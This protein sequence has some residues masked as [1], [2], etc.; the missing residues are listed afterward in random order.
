[1]NGTITQP[2]TINPLELIGEGIYA[3][4]V[5]TQKMLNHLREKM[6]T[7]LPAKYGSNLWWEKS[8]HE[9]VESITNGRGKKFK[10]YEQAV[11]YLTK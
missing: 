4:F 7:F 1:M 11:K 10:T 8:N 5:T 3:A 2:I 9:A 6:V